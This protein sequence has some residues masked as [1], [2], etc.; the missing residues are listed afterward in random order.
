MKNNFI[1][2]KIE[3]ALV[4]FLVIFAFV[5]NFVVASRGVFPV[6][7][8]IHFDSGYRI[9]N[10]EFP[11]KDYWIVH[12]FFIDYI[13]SLFFFIFGNNWTAYLIHSSLFNSLICFFS[14]H[15]FKNYLKIG[16]KE[17]ILLSLSLAF[18]AYPV[19]GTPFLDLHS[20]F[21]SLFAVFFVIMGILKK[22]E[23]YWFYSG[24]LLTVAFF[25]KQV[26]AGY[27][28]FTTTIFCLYYSIKNQ[29]LSFF[30]YYFLGGLSSL[31]FLII[32]LLIQKI[33]ISDFLLQLIF[34]PKSF[35][36]NRY[37]NYELN[38]KNFFLDFKFIYFY[39]IIIFTII[40]M[41]T[42]HK[43]YYIYDKKIK[44]LIIFLLFTFSS[45]FHQ[46]YT[47]N[48]IYIF[49]I[50]PLLAGYSIYF[51]N[52]LKIKNKNIIKFLIIFGCLLLTIK[53]TIR[54]DIERK[55][56]ELNNTRIEN[57]YNFV[58]FDKKFKGLK[59]ISPY[60]QNPQD[61]IENLILLRKILKEKKSNVMLITEYKFYSLLLEKKLFS[62]S[63]TFDNISYPKK[64]SSYYQ[65]YKDFLK[66]IVIKNN[67]TD[68]I[69]FEKTEIKKERLDHL[70]F[71]YIPDDC[72]NEIK[73]QKF[74]TKLEIKICEEL[75][76]DR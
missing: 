18:L 70:V 39:L 42:R 40:F 64:N 41:I 36:E 34:F 60:F 63:R 44:A 24:L 48:Q 74:I 30:L 54:F 29:N 27:I 7:T 23:F 6:D 65:A 51:L 61:E 62:P 58:N 17:S 1:K 16:I 9:L 76:N 32:F 8:F 56:H 73:I 43:K 10:G 35:G 28:I 66:K 47:K 72:F 12:G 45:I 22:K 20:N 46:I 52:D 25:C 55:F 50:I 67:I 49:F 14:F 3:I 57:S 19:S 38:F 5:I 13:Q 21:F 15:I 59:W 4:F 68:I 26:P 33:A 37:L 2:N 31:I 11:V 75:V 53:Y 71:N 69:V